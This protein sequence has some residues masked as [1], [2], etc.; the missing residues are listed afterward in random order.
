MNAYAHAIEIRDDSNLAVNRYIGAALLAFLLFNLTIALAGADPVSTFK[1]NST[2]N[3][4]VSDCRFAGSTPHR[5]ATHVV[6]CTTNSGQKT[7]CDF[8][9]KPANCTVTP[10]PKASASTNGNDTVIEG[11]IPDGAIEQ[12]DTGLA[13]PGSVSSTESVLVEDTSGQVA[14]S[15]VATNAEPESTDPEETEVV[16]AQSAP[17]DVESIPS[18][19][20]ED[21]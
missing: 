18:F 17:A 5:E 3:Q 20:D 7:T 9:Q 12:G 8:N 19:E 16:S 21:S 1:N 11:N 4:W 6:S 2:Q 15:E 10:P 13:S 14:P